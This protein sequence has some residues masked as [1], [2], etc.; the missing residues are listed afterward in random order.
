MHLVDIEEVPGSIPGVPTT[1]SIGYETKVSDV[2]APF[3]FPG[4]RKSDKSTELA[5]I[6]THAPSLR[7]PGR[8]PSLASPDA[9]GRVA[10]VLAVVGWE[11]NAA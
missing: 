3:L 4:V 1:F 10:S 11:A 8:M 9:R 7:G 6:D 2:L 5:M